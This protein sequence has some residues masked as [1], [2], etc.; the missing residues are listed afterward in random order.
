LQSLG[1]KAAHGCDMFQGG[2]A[3]FGESD[4]SQ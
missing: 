1:E 2:V 3:L 4:P